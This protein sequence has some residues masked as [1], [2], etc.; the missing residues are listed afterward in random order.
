MTTREFLELIFGDSNGYLIIA[1]KDENGNLTNNKPFKYPEQLNQA[2]AYCSVREDEDLWFSPMLFS[3]TRRKASAVQTTPVVYADTDLFDPAGF[4]IE[5][6]LSVITSQDPIKR[7]SYWI[8]DDVYSPL[9]VSTAARAIALT[10]ASKDDEG[11]QAGVDTSGWDLG[12]LLRLPNSVNTK[13]NPPTQVYVEESNGNIYSLE[14]IT[15]AYS[16]ENVPMR[17]QKIDS[18]MPTNLP[19]IKDVLARVTSIPHLNVLYGHEPRQGQDWSD[20][21]YAFVTE[22]LR[23]GFTA[24]ETLQA[25][26]QAPYNKY[27]RDNRPKSDLWE[28]D[29]RNAAADPENRPRATTERYVE[30]PPPA[31]PKS[32]GIAKELAVELMS[33]EERAMVTETWVD[34]Y[35]DEYIGTSTDAPKAMH[36]ASALAIMSCIFGEFGK[37]NPEYGESNLGLF[38]IVM[39]ETTKSRKSTVRNKMKE[40]LRHTMLMGDEYDYLLTSDVTPE[41]L[42]D[43]LSERPDQSSLYDRDEAQDLIS[44]IKGGRGYMKGFFETLNE[45]FD[46]KARARARAGKKTNEAR[47]V[48]VQYLMGIRS[49]IQ[50]ELEVRDFKSGYLTRNIFVSGATPPELQ[51]RP[52]QGG[53][54]ENAGLRKVSKM[55]T[56]ARLYW[57]KR[58]PDK[59]DKYIIEF[60]PEAWERLWDFGDDLQKVVAK[61]PRVELLSPSV[62]R[63]TTN[64]MKVAALFAMAEQ[65]DTANMTDLMNAITYGVQWLEDLIIMTE[66]VTDSALQR[67]YTKILDYI[68]QH[69]GIVSK[70]QLL[71]WA[72]TTEN[73]RIFELQEKMETLQ[74]RGEITTVNDQSGQPC[75]QIT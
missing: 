43:I 53:R 37:I 18:D 64:I 55:I 38:F 13:H 10:H 26:W 46:G 36:V 68:N 1:T 33:D 42:I 52:R 28:Y 51:R 5:P 16:P 12:Q 44:D 45:L 75:Y 65:R 30:E 48:F 3:I 17:A 40:M 32:L 29:V 41:T 56:D 72:G 62:E 70:T 11:N 4:L 31:K 50:E 8:L 19:D 2:V 71:R 57:A 22:L 35:I 39:A 15:N 20:L 49:Q 27:K 25:A 14:E 67:D 58:V 61:H 54:R 60:T 21:L 59:S 23:S 24:E 73:W 69:D 63:L 7:H 6:S 9:A 47:V 66:G 74:Q 34:S